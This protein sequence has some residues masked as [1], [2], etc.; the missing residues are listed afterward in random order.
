MRASADAAQLLWGSA[1]IRGHADFVQAR[2]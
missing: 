2:I 1:L